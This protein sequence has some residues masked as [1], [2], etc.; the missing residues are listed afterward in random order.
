MDLHATR[1]FCDLVGACGGRDYAAMAY[2]VP[3]KAFD[4]FDPQVLHTYSGMHFAIT[5]KH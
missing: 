2:F 4:H 3:P 5:I 1:H